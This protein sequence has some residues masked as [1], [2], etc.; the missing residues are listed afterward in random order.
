MTDGLEAVTSTVLG[1]ALDAA[2]LR[3]QAIATNIANA[4]VAGYVPLSVSFETQLGDARR[5]LAAGRMLDASALNDVAPRMELDTD[6]RSGSLS[7]DIALDAEVAHLAQNA[8]QYQALAKGL[9]K[10]YALLSMATSDGKK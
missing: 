10:H 5:T 4:N 1:L 8:I 3:Q 7:T 6:S 2:S 9:A